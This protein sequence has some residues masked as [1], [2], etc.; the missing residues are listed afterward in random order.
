M[1]YW[2]VAPNVMEFAKTTNLAKSR[3]GIGHLVG[4]KPGDQK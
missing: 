1:Q 2:T 3:K 4:S